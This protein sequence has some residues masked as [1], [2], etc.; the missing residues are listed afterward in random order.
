MFEPSKKYKVKLWQEKSTENHKRYV[1][2]NDKGEVINDCNGFVSRALTE[3]EKLSGIKITLKGKKRLMTTKKAFQFFNCDE[4]KSSN[5]M[6]PT[7]ND[8]IY[9]DYVEPREKLWRKVREE[10]RA[11]NIEIDKNCYDYVR[12]QILKG[13]PTKA[14]EYITYGIIIKH[15]IY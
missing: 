10:F 1:V 5:S 3:Q 6:N 12:T 7:Y 15:E 14:S 2:V 11:G 9:R 8:T 13:D 4:W